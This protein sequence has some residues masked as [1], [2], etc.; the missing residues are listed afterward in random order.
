MIFGVFKYLSFPGVDTLSDAVDFLVHLSTV[1]ITLLTSASHSKLD[2]GRMPGADT[3]DFAKTLVRLA[4][5]LACV[6]TRC[7]T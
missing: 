4:R 5:K 6:P 2:A 7:N 3:S 1:M